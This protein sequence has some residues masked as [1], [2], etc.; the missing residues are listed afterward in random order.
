MN[1]SIEGSLVT[2]PANDGLGVAKVIFQSERYANTIC[3]KLYRKRFPD[4]NSIRQSDFSGHFDLYFTSLDGFKKKRWEIVAN[5]SVSSDERA[6]TRRTS[7]GEIWVEDTH[8]GP[9]SD[10]DLATLPK[11]LTHGF[12]LIEKY[13]GR[14]PMAISG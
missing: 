3:L 14:Y 7:G 8:L 9:A 4:G 10:T 2:I 13:A 6:L 5:E 1:Y 11:M 12:K